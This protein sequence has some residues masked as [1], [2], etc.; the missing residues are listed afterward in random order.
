[1]SSSAFP[2]PTAQLVALYMQ[3]IFYGIDLITVAYGLRVL[4]WTRDGHFKGRTRITWIMV[5]TTIAMFTIATL[6][7]ALGLVHNL[8][9]FIYYAGPGGPTVVFEDLS[10]WLNI[11]HTSDYVIQTFIGDGIMVY[12]CYVVYDRNWKVVLLPVL[13]WLTETVCGCVGVS[14]EATL[15]TSATLNEARLVP[16]ITTILSL[17]L[18]MTTMTTGLIVYRIMQVNNSVASHDI[19]RVGGNLRLTRVV[20]ILVE[21]GLMYTTSVVVFFGT[22]LASNNAQYGVSEVVVQLIPISFTLI[23]IR[24]D[25]AAANETSTLQQTSTTIHWN[26]GP[27]RLPVHAGVDGKASDRTRVAGSGTAISGSD[28]YMMDDMGP[29]SDG[30]HL[31]LDSVV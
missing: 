17:T 12:R 23:L 11:V 30:W 25:Q 4:L 27:V 29:G 9:A 18:A 2:M 5:G 28:A 31:E 19:T 10:S 26:S 22:F 24:A 16:Y 1:M 7:V 21:S 15:H 13:L 14:I 8:Q 6:E 3:C 20:R